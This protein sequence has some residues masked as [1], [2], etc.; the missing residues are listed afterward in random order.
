MGRDSGRRP[1]AAPIDDRRE[2]S[3]W[4]LYSWAN[5]AW[6]T[7][8][9]TVLIGPWLLALAGNAAG[10]GGTLFSV[11]GWHL[12]PD[13][14]PSLVIAVAALLQVVTLPALGAAADALNAKRRLLMLTCGAGSVITALLATTGGSAWLYAGVLFL[15]GNVVFGA[16]DVVYNAFLPQISSA[17]ERDRVSS[18][19]YAV[20]YL[21]AGLLLALNLVTLRLHGAL[22]IGETTAVRA[23]YVTAALWWAVFGAVAIA[24]IRERGAARP[25]PGR[26]GMGLAELRATV[27]ELRN[28]PH[29]TRY[30]L[31]YLFFSDAIS[32]VI[33]LSSTYITHEL[34]ASNASAAAPFLFS[35][36]L[37]IQ[38]IAVVGSLLFARV[39]AHI[40]TKNA[41]LAA[42]VVWCLVI[43][44][45]YAAL[46]TKTEAVAMGVV[47]ALVLGGSQALARS[48]YSQMVPRGR[49]ATFFGFYEVCDRGTSWIA[50]LLFTLVVNATGSFRQAILS[51]IAL[52][53][54]GFVL[55]AAT[56]VDRARAE[57]GTGGAPATV[58]E[59]SAP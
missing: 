45:A 4:A 22:G 17:G 9:G 32:A 36:I 46:H 27:A 8:V 43:V 20:G 44:Y 39:A 15:A 11:L 21:G 12:H 59:P 54:L 35:L 25:G 58:P 3:A 56:N 55:V 33:A 23:C 47:I 13:A 24:R 40:G 30:L 2:L 16:T 48:L 14:Y 41:V 26:V 10:A 50:P 34:F 1:H 52:F 49:E 51:L 31:G 42:L 6:V 37:L 28:R 29:T 38:F 18:R 5:H 53:V 19:G 57:G 7:T